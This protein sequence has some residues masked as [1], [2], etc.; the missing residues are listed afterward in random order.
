[1]ACCSHT[2]AAH[3]MVPSQERPLSQHGCP[4]SP[5]RVFVDFTECRSARLGDV[6]PGWAA[7]DTVAKATPRLRIQA[8]ILVVRT[9]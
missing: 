6:A 7:K 9:F 5:Q 2:P 1:M 3:T 4:D 8:A